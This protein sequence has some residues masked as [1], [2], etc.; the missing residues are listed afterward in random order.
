M[1]YSVA[2]VALVVAP[3]PGQALVIARS[4][5]G[6]ARSGVLT[7]LGL[8]IGTL[9]HTVAATLGL[10]AILDTSAGAFALVKYA[11]AAYLVTLGLS[12]LW[13]SRRSP[14]EPGV[15]REGTR[16][17]RTTAGGS[18]GHDQAAEPKVAVFFLAFLPQF[19][20]PEPGAVLAQFL[21]LGLILATFGFVFDDSLAVVA[22]RARARLATSAGFT[23]WRERVAGT[24]L[25]GLGLRLA[26]PDRH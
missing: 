12:M 22:G 11:G 18:C 17:H 13:R 4:V 19:V 26:L 2:A 9:A 7:S 10:S 23:A 3:G 1:T 21:T 5:Q 15:A 24:V 16:R 8:E 20:K 6:G 14:P 25:I